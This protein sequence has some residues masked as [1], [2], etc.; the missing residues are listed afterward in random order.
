LV[1][2]ANG[3]GGP[4]VRVAG[5]AATFAEMGVGG[6]EVSVAAGAGATAR[7]GDERNRFPV[8]WLDGAVVSIRLGAGF[9]G[10]AERVRVGLAGARKTCGAACWRT[11]FWV[12][13][14]TRAVLVVSIG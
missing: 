4:V 3:V 11:R 8:G 6:P 5:A 2:A 10:A 14:W 12:G 1:T 9:A 13:S 7:V